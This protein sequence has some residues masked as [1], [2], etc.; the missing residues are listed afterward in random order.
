MKLGMI[1]SN[2]P[3]ERRI[4]LLPEDIRDFENELL[5]ETGFGEFMDIADT[6]YEQA[7]CRIMSREEIFSRAD[8]I[9]SLKLIQPTD[10]ALIRPG[11][12]IIG[13]THPLGSGKP[14]MEE[15]AYPKDLVV[16]DLDNRFPQIFYHDKMIR[17]DWIPANAVYQNSFYAGFAGVLHAFLSYGLIPDDNTRVAILG[18]GNVAQ[19]AFHGVS[20]FTSNVKLYYRRTLPDF[21]KKAPSYDMIIN[22]IEVGSWGKPIMT[23]AQQKTLKK[24]AFV[25]DVAADAGNA[26]EGT[27]FTTLDEPIYKEDGVY[28]FVVPNTPALAYRNVSKVLSR[29]FSKYIFK[30]S[31]AVFK[32]VAHD[33]L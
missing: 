13:W 30:K 9:F 6:D 8:G 33:S 4:P 32:E 16:V 3:N 10:Y 14:F 20:K 26:I 27:R 7:G 11:Q 29:Q 23:K 1:K 31:I 28:Y 15:Q 22:G 24:G 12:I 18:S 5:I 19:G 2:F 25:I 17:A 21:E